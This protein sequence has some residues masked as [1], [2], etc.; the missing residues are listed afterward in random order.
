MSTTTNILAMS[1]PVDL[2]NCSR[3]GPFYHEQMF[4]LRDLESLN[5]SS[6]NFTGQLIPNQ[7]VGLLKKLIP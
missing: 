7:E 4:E 1:L 3:S 6:N 5:V 2:H